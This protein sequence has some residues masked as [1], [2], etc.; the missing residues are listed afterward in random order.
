[1][2]QVGMPINPGAFGGIAQTRM[3]PPVQQPQP[4]QFPM[5]GAPQGPLPQ[6]QRGIPAGMPAP[7]GMQQPNRQ[8]LLAQ[9]LERSNQGY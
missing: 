4:M 1:M 5:Q 6:M 2:N 3:P 9:M 8:Q 7:Q